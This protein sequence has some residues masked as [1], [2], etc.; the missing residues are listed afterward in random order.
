MRWLTVLLSALFSV[1]LSAQTWLPIVRAIVFR[2]GFVYTFREGTVKPYRGEVVLLADFLKAREGTLYAYLPE[3]K[4]TITRLEF[5]EVTL[6]EEVQKTERTFNDLF[7]TLRGNE[8]KKVRVITKTNEQLEG[9]LRIVTP[10]HEDPTMPR[11]PQK[12]VRVAYIALEGETTALV[13]TD[14]IERVIFLE[15]ANLKEVRE[16]KVPTTQKRLVVILEGVEEGQEMKMGLAALESGLRWDATYRIVVPNRPAKEARLELVATI[17]NRELFLK[18]TVLLLAVGT[19]NFPYRM[20]LASLIAPPEMWRGPL[21]PGLPTMGA[22][23]PTGVA[24]PAAQLAFRHEFAATPALPV[25]MALPALEA[26]QLVFYETPP[27]SLKP[28]ERVSLVLFSQTLPCR[29]VFEWTVEDQP[30]PPQ[31]TGRESERIP[32]PM[33]VRPLTAGVWYALALRNTLSVPLTTG[34]ATAYHEWRPIGQGLLTF[35]AVGEEAI[36]RL[37]P[38]TE[39][40]GDHEER[41]LAREPVSEKRRT[42]KGEEVIQVGWWLTIE[43]TLRLRNT[44]K[45]DAAVIVRRILT[46]EVVS[47]SDDGEVR[48]VPP[49]RIADRN[50]TS[51]IRWQLTLPPGEKRLTYR[52]RKFV[53]MQ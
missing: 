30:P 8:G 52:Y 19:P 53:P 49:A 20:Q 51:H 48:V 34:I 36:V 25:E 10:L 5:R 38:A 4:G 14:Q 39:I 41:E 23:G 37:S 9:I 12:P 42:E 3:G 1:P 50:P 18:D 31:P 15:P 16:T 40:V 21:A 43:G 17:D 26:A 32:P 11:D 46:G 47:V 45:E 13:R 35:T 29:E 24:P 7:D 27:L 22:L 28:G 6:G 2:D 44:Q 33:P